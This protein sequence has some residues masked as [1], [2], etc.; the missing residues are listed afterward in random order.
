MIGEFD[1]LPET[2]AE[3]ERVGDLTR[4]FD[5][6]PEGIVIHYAGLTGGEVLSGSLWV[7]RECALDF[8][9]ER[10]PNLTCGLGEVRNAL[11][12]PEAERFHARPRGEAGGAVLVRVPGGHFPEKPL[13]GLIAALD[14]L[15]P[16]GPVLYEFRSEHPEAVAANAEVTALHSLFTASPGLD[17]IAAT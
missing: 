2:M 8:F 14:V 13:P 1:P 3:Y 12:G 6:I 9:A 15:K 7:S 10:D 17:A 4:I 5:D 11:I 16:D